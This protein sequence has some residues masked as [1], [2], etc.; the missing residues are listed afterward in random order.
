MAAVHGN[1]QNSAL[2]S[3]DI[4]WSQAVA[5]AQSLEGQPSAHLVPPPPPPYTMKPGICSGAL[6]CPANVCRLLKREQPRR[7]A[8]AHVE[9]ASAPSR[10]VDHMPH[11][12]AACVQAAHTSVVV[13]ERAG[14]KAM[15]N[16]LH[17]P[18]VEA[19]IVQIKLSIK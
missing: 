8:S 18:L 10:C 4:A 3:A 16:P 14:Q 12:D 15:C 17:D 5:M 13:E 6:A 9:A 2:S 11:Q 7:A 1:G 19:A